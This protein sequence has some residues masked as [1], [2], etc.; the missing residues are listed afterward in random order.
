MI[1]EWMPDLV[2]QQPFKP[3][4]TQVYPLGGALSMCVSKLTHTHTHTE[5]RVILEQSQACHPACNSNSLEAEAG[6]SKACLSNI[7]L[8]NYLNIGRWKELE[9]QE[10][11]W[12]PRN[13]EESAQTQRQRNPKIQ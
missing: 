8:V 13:S 11:P 5:V 3:A 1:K 12:W 9:I 10:G 2:L 7:T 4:A 6:Q